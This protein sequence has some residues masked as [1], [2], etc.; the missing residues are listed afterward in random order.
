MNRLF[1]CRDFVDTALPDTVGTS[2]VE[3]IFESLSFGEAR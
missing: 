1:S 3:Q 2:E